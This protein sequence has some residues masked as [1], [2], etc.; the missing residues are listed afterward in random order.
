MAGEKPCPERKAMR[1][2]AILITVLGIGLSLGTCLAADMPELKDQRD[3]DSYSLGYQYGETF[4]KQ[5]IDIDMDL[6][7]RAARSEVRTGETD[8]PA[9]PGG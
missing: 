5:G 7:T 1:T 6:F 3:R 2:K 9:R 4:K 8:T